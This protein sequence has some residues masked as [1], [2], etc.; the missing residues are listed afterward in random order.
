M[1]YVYMHKYR[2][3]DKPRHIHAPITPFR[4]LNLCLNSVNDTRKTHDP[5]LLRGFTQKKPID[6]KALQT[7]SKNAMLY[8]NSS[9]TTAYET[10]TVNKTNRTLQSL[11]V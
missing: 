4:Y 5:D 6:F 10:V 9:G 2:P 7:R 1:L 3:N 11:P 8:L